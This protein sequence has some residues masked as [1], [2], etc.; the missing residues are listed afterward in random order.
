MATERLS[1][2]KTREILRHKWVLGLGYRDVANSVDVSLDGVWL[3]VD[4]AK[5]AGLDWPTVE[6]WTTQPGGRVHTRDLEVGLRRRS[7][8]ARGS[9]WS[10][11]GYPLNYRASPASHSASS[12]GAAADNGGYERQHVLTVHNKRVL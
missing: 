3:V 9:I 2:R 1:M 4:R 7:P 6:A 5:K 12:G 8:T 10:D 11:A